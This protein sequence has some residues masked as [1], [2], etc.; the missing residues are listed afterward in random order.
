MTSVSTALS[1]ILGCAARR[2][3]RRASG[4][5]R[6]SRPRCSCN[7]ACAEPVALSCAAG[8]G[9][10]PKPYSRWAT[11]VCNVQGAHSVAGV[12]GAK[13]RAALCTSPALR[14]PV[15]Q[16]VS[17]AKTLLV[18]SPQLVHPAGALNAQRD[19]CRSPKVCIEGGV[20]PSFFHSAAT[21]LHEPEARRIASR[22]T[23]RESGGPANGTWSAAVKSW[24]ATHDTLRKKS[25]VTSHS[26]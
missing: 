4:N 11:P 2:R 7:V 25:R 15:C 20:R 22:R 18:P 1:V 14:V 8:S 26:R 6:R 10:W 24:A 16:Q 9:S 12:S 23:S 13:P 3:Y 5:K 21:C 17:L 19:S